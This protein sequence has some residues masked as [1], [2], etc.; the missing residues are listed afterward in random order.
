MHGTKTDLF[1]PPLSL[2]QKS[3]AI[4][5]GK[6]NIRKGLGRKKVTMMSTGI[7]LM[8][9]VHLSLATQ[10]QLLFLCRAGMTKLAGVMRDI[11]GIFAMAC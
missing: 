4:P 3:M 7:S 5:A 6:K 8:I 10:D 2:K 9:T 11:K 1:T